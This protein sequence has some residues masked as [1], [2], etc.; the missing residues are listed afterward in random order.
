MKIEALPEGTVAHVHTPVYQI[1][2]EGEYTLL[3]TFLETILT[4][5]WYP[6]CVATLSRMTKGRSGESF[7]DN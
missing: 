5:V 2:A 7:A 3:V 4:Q 6:T 1:T